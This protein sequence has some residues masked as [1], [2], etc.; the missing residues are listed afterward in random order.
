MSS[1]PSH[2]HHLV[3]SSS[4]EKLLLYRHKLNIDLYPPELYLDASDIRR[5]ICI[6]VHIV[7]IS[8]SLVASF[9]Q[10]KKRSGRVW[11]AVF[12]G[13]LGRI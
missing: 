5:A 8:P 6:Y 2:G 1:N 9:L 7:L 11:L 13:R 4:T 10:N 12:T 3:F